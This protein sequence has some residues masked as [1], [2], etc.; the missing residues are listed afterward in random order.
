[1]NKYGMIVWKKNDGKWRKAAIRYKEWWPTHIS[2]TEKSHITN[3]G[4]A[5]KIVIW[6]P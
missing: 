2:T 3:D 4:M 6:K 5:V 1:M